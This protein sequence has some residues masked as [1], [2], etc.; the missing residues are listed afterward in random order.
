LCWIEWTRVIR[1]LSKKYLKK[2]VMFDI[3][4]PWSGYRKEWHLCYYQ[5]NYRSEDLLSQKL[6]SFKNGNHF[7]IETWSNWSIEELK[8]QNV[9]FD[10]IVRSL[11]SRELVAS[12]VAPLDGLCRNLSVG[13]DAEFIPEL[14]CKKRFTERLASIPKVVDRIA[15]LEDVF[16]AKDN[17]ERIL[18]KY[19]LVVDDVATSGTTTKFILQAIKSKYPMLKPFLFTLAKTSRDEGANAHIDPSRFWD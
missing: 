18:N 12:G 14:V 6:L 7:D 19:V 8:R 9:K 4:S 15:Q 16:I 11:G 5:P 10:F 17:F 13:L 1:I 2:S 3:T